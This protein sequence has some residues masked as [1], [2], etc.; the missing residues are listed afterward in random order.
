[1]KIK[2]LKFKNWIIL[3]VMGALGLSSCHQQKTITQQEEPPQE[4][5]QPRNEIRLMYG[6]P[7][8]S[9][10][11]N[12]KKDNDEARPNPKA[13]QPTPVMYGVPTVNFHVKGKVVDQ[14][15]NPV[16]GLRVTLMS[17][18]VSADG[19]RNPQNEFYQNYINRASDTTDTDGVFQ[20]QT[21]DRPWEKQ[22]VMVLDTDGS[23]NDSYEEQ[24]LS[25]EFPQPSGESKGWNLGTSEQELTITVKKK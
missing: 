17:S 16:K 20:C 3:S 6:V 19:I 4:G 23:K 12:I 8:R 15:G 18:D 24:V 11:D 2:F 5:P 22:H 10:D 25:V 21:S 14:Q 7:T 13:E 1:M 9:F